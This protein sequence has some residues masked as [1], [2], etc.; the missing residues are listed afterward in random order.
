MF[1][2]CY[3][4]DKDK[5]VVLKKG[6]LKEIDNVTTTLN[7]SN[8]II[9]KYN[10]KIND[11]INRNYGYMNGLLKYRGDMPK[12]FIMSSDDSKIKVNDGDISILYKKDERKKNSNLV[13]ERDIKFLRS[14]KNKIRIIRKLYNK[15]NRLLEPEA[16]F[17]NGGDYLLEYA[18]NPKNF[19]RLISNISSS[20]KIRN[21]EDGSISDF[22]YTYIRLMDDF[23]KEYGID[24]S[25]GL[26]NLDDNNKKLSKKAIKGTIKESSL[27]LDVLPI[28]KEREKVKEQNEI[29]DFYIEEKDDE[30]T[31]KKY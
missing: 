14:N 28:Y 12:M 24:S 13:L 25:I 1:Y 31:W 4:Y 15:F 26:G 29:D 10:D 11:F 21:N 20:L 19:N 30:R 18:A 23:F 22:S 8:G 16:F 17:A 27:E 9:F 3:G 6:S 5:C 2:L 7:N